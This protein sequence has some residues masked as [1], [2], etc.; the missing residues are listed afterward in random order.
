M[1][2]YQQSEKRPLTCHHTV[3]EKEVEVVDTYTSC[4]HLGRWSM[5]QV[6]EHVQQAAAD[7]GSVVASV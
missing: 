3:P 7:V 1:L 2:D 4:A 5:T 6:I